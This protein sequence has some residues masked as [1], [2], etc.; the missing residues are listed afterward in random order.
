MNL[1]PLPSNVV[2]ASLWRR[3][4]ALS[5]DSLLLVGIWFLATALLLPLTDGQA[6]PAQQP[7]FQ[8]YLF[9]ITFGFFAYFWLHGG[10]TLGMQ[11]WRIRLVAQTGQALTLWQVL[12]RFVVA[13]AGAAA[14]GLGF[15]WALYDAQGR[16]WHDLAAGT[17]VI[18]LPKI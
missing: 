7:L 10:Q 4:A 15:W 1:P 9:G 11:A 17:Q 13:V 3:L 5:Y 12:L 18:Y 16:T 2:V 8:M 14:L 6:V